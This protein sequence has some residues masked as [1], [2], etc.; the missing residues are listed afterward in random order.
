MLTHSHALKETP[1]DIAYSAH[2]ILVLTKTHIHLININTNKEDKIPLPHIGT[3]TDIYSAEDKFTL[4]S[5]TQ[6]YEITTEPFA[7]NETSER[8]TLAKPQ[9]YTVEVADKKMTITD[10]IFDTVFFQQNFEVTPMVHYLE[11][12]GTLYIVVDA[13]TFSMDLSA[14]PT[15]ADAMLFTHKEESP[16]EKLIKHIDAKK[17]LEALSII[18]NNIVDVI[19]YLRYAP[20]SLQHIKSCK[21]S[22]ESNTNQITL[23]KSIRLWSEED[24]ESCFAMFTRLIE[25]D[26]EIG[27]NWTCNLLSCFVDGAFRLLASHPDANALISKIYD[28]VNEARDFSAACWTAASV[29]GAFIGEEHATDAHGDVWQPRAAW[30]NRHRVKKMERKEKP[31]YAVEVISI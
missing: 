21:M 31:V 26:Y 15:I 1:L 7:L 25:Q 4:Q 22:L 27:Q 11:S 5:A 8:I 16:Q 12:T 23:S 19:P 6:C 17:W 13:E 14:K 20:D 29:V 2:G 18:E 3:F 30:H 9:Y 24:S 10:T 28:K